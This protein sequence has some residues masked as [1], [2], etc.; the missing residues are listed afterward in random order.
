MNEQMSEKISSNGNDDAARHERGM[1]TFTRMFGDVAGKTIASIDEISP[2]LSRYLVDYVFGDVLA[3]P[4][5]DLKSREVAT[6]AAL[7]AMGTAGPQLRAHIHCA[8]N[9][10]C[11]QQEIIEIMIQM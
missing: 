6:V 8:L 7:T 11:S 3:R 2:D 9:L 5:L 1:A 4:A 10:G